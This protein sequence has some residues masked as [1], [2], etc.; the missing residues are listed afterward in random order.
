MISVF[1][2]SL[3]DSSDSKGFHC[4]ESAVSPLKKTNILYRFLV[5]QAFKEYTYDDGGREVLI[6]GFFF[7]LLGLITI[8]I[9]FVQVGISSMILPNISSFSSF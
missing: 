3:S 4:L 6:S 5:F 2:V 7:L 9:R 1:L 8:V